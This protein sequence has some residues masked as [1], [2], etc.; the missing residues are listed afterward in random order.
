MAVYVDDAAIE[1]KGK[2]RF[3]MSADTLQELH[4]FAESIGI[5]RCWYHR[6]ARHPHYDITTEQREDA[7]KAGAQPVQVR[8]LVAVAKRMDCGKGD[9]MTSIGSEGASRT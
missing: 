5:K 8:Q 7:I 1:S 9:R 4:Q 6:G 2:K 3:H